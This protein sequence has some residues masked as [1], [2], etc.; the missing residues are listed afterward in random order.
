MHGWMRAVL[1][2]KLSN[3]ISNIEEKITEGSS[4]LVSEN[5]SHKVN[6]VL[7]SDWDIL[8]FGSYLNSVTLKCCEIVK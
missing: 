1:V 3:T 2:G 8:R 5:F 6:K 4:S 7:H